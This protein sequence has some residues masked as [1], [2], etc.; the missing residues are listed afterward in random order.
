MKLLYNKVFLGHDTG[1]HPEN[2]QR[3]EV[4]APDKES[5]V[6]NGGSYLNL[7][8]TSDYIDYVKSFCPSGGHLDADTMVSPESYAAAV[9]AVG[10]SVM[11]SQTNNFALVRPPG[12]HAYPSRSTGF[13][14]FNNIAIAT[15]NLV[16]Q[17]KRVFIFDFDG[18]CGDGTEAIFYD[19]DK[20]FYWSLHQSPA[21]PYKGME[22]EI[23]K[24]KGKGFTINVCLPSESGDDIYLRALEHLIPAAEQF[25][26]DVVAVSAG[27]DAHH[28]DSLL[29]LRLTTTMYYKIGQILRERFQNI[30]AVLEG[31]YNL[32]Y[33]P[34]CL[35]NFMRG[36]NNQPIGF[37]ESPTES[38]IQVINEF[39]LN[40]SG[41]ENNLAVFWKF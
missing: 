7:V 29:N 2:R 30:F 13:C 16:K 1:M 3:L 35:D 31:G 39:D 24:G 15:A 11:A 23:G 4:C 6:E 32:K 20:V 41:L 10:A 5:V 8:H 36:I 22:N 17:G 34:K 14:V 40:L 21:F 19:T 37:E 12:H 25:H 28:A 9:H 27:F 33:L 18:H 38:S 26:P